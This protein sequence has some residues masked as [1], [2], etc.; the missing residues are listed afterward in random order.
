MNQ[1][2]SRWGDKCLDDFLEMFNF[3]MTLLKVGVILNSEANCF[4]AP[5]D[6]GNQINWRLESRKSFALNKMIT[7]NN[8]I[9]RRKK[10]GIAFDDLLPSGLRVSAPPPDVHL[11]DFNHLIVNFRPGH[12]G[13]GAGEAGPATWAR[14]GEFGAWGIRGGRRRGGRR[15]HAR[16]GG[17]PTQP[18]LLHRRPAGAG[19]RAPLCTSRRGWCGRGRR[20]GVG[21]AD[22]VRPEP[23]AAG[24]RG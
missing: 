4:S 14:Q 19:R 24:G 2:H 22:L 23:L 3:N 7:R 8:E 21:Q 16:N 10:N 18:P 12:G 1:T 17:A 20:R 6:S 11:G 15:W 13:R 5:A 9:D